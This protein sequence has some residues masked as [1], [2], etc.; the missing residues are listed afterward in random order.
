MLHLKKKKTNSFIV[1]TYILLILLNLPI[2]VC[3][4]LFSMSSLLLVIK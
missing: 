3:P 1:E 4:F 2:C